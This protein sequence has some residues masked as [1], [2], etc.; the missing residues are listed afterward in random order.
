MK[1][2]FVHDKR[3]STWLLLIIFLCCATGL[4]M[5]HL[6]T[7]SAVSPSSS[8]VSTTLTTPPTASS[9][10]R[11]GMVEF[12][13]TVRYNNQFQRTVTA[14]RRILAPREVV[15][16]IY[17]AEEL[18]QKIKAGE[19]D[20]F[21]ASSGF[22]WRMMPYGA[23][24]LA[25]QTNFH[26]VDPNHSA[27]ISY[28]VR[29]D[30]SFQKIE[31]LKGRRLGASYPTAFYGYRIG[32]AEIALS[33]EDPYQYFSKVEYSGTPQ[34]EGVLSLLNRGA[35]DMIFLPV[36]AM[37]ELPPQVSAQYRVISPKNSGSI[38]CQLSTRTYPGH[39]LVTL[40][41][42]DPELARLVTQTVLSIPRR[43]D[44]E[45]WSI[46]TD[47]TAVDKLY[48]V[49]K[50][51]PYQYLN[52]T[53]LKEWT[54]KNKSLLSVLLI[55][56]A[57]IVAHS[58][59]SKQLVEQRT[60]ELHATARKEKE[61]E[62]KFRRTSLAMEQL[63]KANTV[64]MLSSMITH[65]L[66][67]PL[68]SLNHY[69]DAQK[70][71][72]GQDTLKTE[73]LKR[74][75]DKMSE[76]T[77]RMRAIIDKVRQYGKNEVRLEH[78]VNLSG[79]LEKLHTWLK[80]ENPQYRLEATF[81]ENLWTQ[82]DE[83]EL[84]LAVWNLVKNAREAALSRENGYVLIQS[85]IKEGKISLVVENSGPVMTQEEVD[86]LRTLLMSKKSNGLGLGIPIVVPIIELSGG[87][88]SFTPLSTGGLR[89]EVRL[90][91]QEKTLSE[92]KKHVE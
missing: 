60:E 11:I 35:V 57:G 75:R 26:F 46:A 44:T 76:Q 31:D 91:L 70:V 30:S 21:L 3:V 8:L 25:T 27:G 53:S 79:I 81:S 62:E 13:S 84:E 48:H 32:L 65:E 22:Y 59:R 49:L 54:K 43:G 1:K 2:L 5:L 52:D 34:L 45:W 90:P 14:L 87:H 37:E 51:G 29:K 73:L 41:G 66:T 58:I 50:I 64:G 33:G 55:I 47:F 38:H 86:A 83:L 92:E 28:V 10:V 17:S 6:Y 24:S 36:C 40:N 61:L 80:L 78:P 74:S 20:F 67:Q 88:L 15:F 42:V 18:E 4:V 77:T 82:G 19:I 7:S 9:Q 69:L 56:I 89:A 63:Q 85:G 12:N 72:L 71:L 39:T 68:S 23:R 16:D